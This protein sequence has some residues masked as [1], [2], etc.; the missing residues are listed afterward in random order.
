MAK[1][2]PPKRSSPRACRSTTGAG[3]ACRFICAPASAFRARVTEIAIQFRRAPHLVFRG[4]DVSTNTL[5]L[6]IQP[7]E[8]ISISFHAKLPGQEMNLKTVTMDFSYQAAF[9][10][11]ER[12]AYAT[13]MNDCMRGDATLFDRADGVEAAWA[14]VDPDSGVFSVEQSPN[15]PTM[16]RVPGA[17]TKP[18]NY[19][20]AMADTGGTL[21]AS[22]RRL[23]GDA[24]VSRPRRGRRGPRRG[25]SWT[26]RGK[27]SPRTAA[28]MVALS[29]G[30]TPRA[31][32][33]LAGL[34]GI[35]RPG[36]LG[37]GAR[38][39]ER[40]ARGASR[41]IRR[42]TTGWRGANC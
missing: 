10:G 24:R 2:R 12:S 20:S 25:I 19:W 1:I 35:S 27:R 28:F 7:D 36:G 32:F 22:P 9:G 41:R 31:M 8:G 5:V 33:A 34:R 42:A 21:I 18:T 39:L 14:L 40:R 6:N 23:P 38:L 3:P 37:Q 16:R 4:Q 29:G 30:N 13:L 17:R 26:M 15:F 11:G